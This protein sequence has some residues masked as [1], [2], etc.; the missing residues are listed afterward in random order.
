MPHVVWFKRDLRV[1]DHEALVAAAAHGACVLL[2]VY[3]PES[4]TAPDFDPSHHRF[5]DDCL[6]ELERAVAE[7]GGRLTYRAGSMPDVLESLHAEIGIDAVHSHEETG[8]ALTYARDRRVRAWCRA[9]GIP[10][11]E[12]AQTGVV[13]RLRSRDGWAKRWEARMLRPIV[14]APPHLETAT[15]PHERRRSPHDLGIRESDKHD[16]LRGGSQAAF[17]LLGSFLDERGVDYRKA[18]SSPLTAPSACSRLSPYLTYGAISL[19]TVYQTTL[20]RE[21]ALRDA[22]AAGERIDARWLGSLRSFSGR[23]HWH[24]HFMQKLEDQ[25]SLEF[26]NQ[27]RA[28]DGL[29]EN[30]FDAARFDAWRAGM[31]GYPM[32]DACMRALH[33]TGWIN[34]RMRAMLMSFASYHL[35]LH[36]RQTAV[37]LGTQFLDLE[38]GIHYPQS[39]MQSGTTGINTVRIYSPAKQIA[40]HD[41]QGEFVRRYVPELARV[42]AEF[43]AEPHAMPPLLAASIGFR[44]GLDY[45]LPIVEHRAAIAAAKLR[46]AVVRRSTGA[47]DEA[48]RVYVKHGSR[49]P[50]PTRTGKR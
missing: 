43:I 7:R 9:R 48:Q 10:W 36:W 11:F 2:Y 16:A 34:F 6:I 37:Y 45:P 28:Y 39:Q 24:C 33:R 25:P 30:D 50:T 26:E 32:V 35:W 31:T 41:P 3:E 23:L 22:R 21:S 27:S 29:R 14:A 42:P 18:M 4:Y 15:L 12:Y 44:A 46:V 5:I 1:D 40:D 20:A 8:N 49:K 38:A 47:K 13:R 19:K 17:A